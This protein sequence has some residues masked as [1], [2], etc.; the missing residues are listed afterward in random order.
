MRKIFGIRG[1]PPQSPEVNSM[2]EQEKLRQ[3]L[4]G[5][6]RD[7]VEHLDLS[8]KG[9][10]TLPPEIGQLAGLTSLDLGRNQLTALP[11]EIWELAGLTTLYLGDNGLTVLPPEIGQLTSLTRLDLDGNQLTALPPEIGQL[12]NLQSLDISAT[13]IASFPSEIQQL[14]NLIRL[15]IVA[16][17]FT[18]IPSEITQLANLRELILVAN[19]MTTLPVEISEM[20]SL[21]RLDLSHNDLTTLPPEIGKLSSL[22]RLNLQYNELTSLPREV[23]ELKSLRRLEAQNNQLTTLPPEI[24]Q[25]TALTRLELSNNELTALPPEIGQLVGLTYLDLKNNPL[26]I[27]PEILQATDDPSRIINYYFEHLVGDKQPLNEAKMLIVGQGGV[28][29]TS[30][31]KRLMDDDFDPD[32]TKTEGI[33]IRDWR[34]TCDGSDIRLNVWDFGGQEIMHA[35]HQ[36]FLTKRSVYVLVLDARQGEQESRIEYWLKLIQSFGSDS[37]IIVVS[38]KSD[39]HELDLDWTG[40][41]RKYPSIKGYVR[42]VSCQTGEGITELRDIIQR[43]VGKLEHIHD[44]LLNNW[45]TVKTQLE[46]MEDDYISYERYQEMCTAQGI[47]D[48]VSLRTLVGFLHDLGI[49]LHFGAHPI[50]G[51]LNILNPE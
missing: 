20:V 45:F 49:V 50:L 17:S 37:P 15:R 28:G 30:L 33:D 26:P 22:E 23:C 8:N 34:V 51:D 19:S 43:E 6:A 7:R 40:L 39:Q 46:E 38:N 12:M 3:I 1:R 2:S 29:K 18:T 4:D 13:R 21:R 14:T 16:D 25:L 24:G 48:E 41:E 42:K 35:T 44:E 11:P 27:P 10:T 9:L 36:F 32:E 5:A 47:T 31:A